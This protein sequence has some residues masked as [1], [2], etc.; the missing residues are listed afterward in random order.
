MKKLAFLAMVAFSLTGCT[1]GG[2]STATSK[3]DTGV[4]QCRKLADPSND[5]GAPTDADLKA[6]RDAYED[7]DHSDL[8]RAGL[9]HLNLVEDYYEGQRGPVALIVA[10]KETLIETCAKY[11]VVVPSPSF[12]APPTF[13]MQPMPKMPEVPLPKNPYDGN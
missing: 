2:D 10:A 7:S 13:S 8:K 11:G 9:A 3:E 6:A 1:G 12:P 4:T 5:K